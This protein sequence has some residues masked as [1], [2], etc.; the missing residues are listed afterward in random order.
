[1]KHLV[2]HIA[3]SPQIMLVLA[4]ISWPRVEASSESE[5]EVMNRRLAYGWVMGRDP[6]PG[7][8]TP[9]HHSPASQMPPS[10]DILW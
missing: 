4:P 9:F 6:V 8:P 5:V 7:P 1:M 2:N 10:P 3:G